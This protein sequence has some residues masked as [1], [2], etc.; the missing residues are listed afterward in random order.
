MDVQEVNEG[1]A[2][3]VLGLVD[4]GLTF[5]VGVQEPGKMCIEAAVCASYG[6]PHGDNPPCVGSAV[7]SH[8]IRQGPRGSEPSRLLS[9]AVWQLT[10]RSLLR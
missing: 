9:L 2:R 5:G 8:R 3:K 1:I 4:A 10:K 6:L 7:R